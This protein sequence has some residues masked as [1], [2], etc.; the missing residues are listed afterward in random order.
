MRYYIEKEYKT[1]YSLKWQDEQITE[2]SK[3]RCMPYISSTTYF[4]SSIEAN[5]ILSLNFRKKTADFHQRPKIWLLLLD[6]NQRH[7]D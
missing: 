7:M 6:L 1:N 2:L 3:T 4:C 5:S